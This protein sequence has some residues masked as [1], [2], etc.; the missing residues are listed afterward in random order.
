MTVYHDNNSLINDNFTSFIHS[1]RSD[2]HWVTSLFWMLLDTHW[3]IT[4][5]CPSSL[6]IRINSISQSDPWGPNNQS[7]SIKTQSQYFDAWRVTQSAVIIYRK[8]YKAEKLQSFVSCAPVCSTNTELALKF[9][10]LPSDGA[11]RTFIW[12]G[13]PVCVDGGLGSGLKCQGEGLEAT[14]GSQQRVKPACLC[15]DEMALFIPRFLFI[16]RSSSQSGIKTKVAC[17][18]VCLLYWEIKTGQNLLDAGAAVLRW[19]CRVYAVAVRGTEFWGVFCPYGNQLSILTI[20]KY[21]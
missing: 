10:F 4:I 13:N 17:L 2:G 19:W 11:T 15:A 21:L 18:P 5:M 7:E 6:N 8:I 12:W 14:D 20:K 16:L 3:P 1:F 9:V